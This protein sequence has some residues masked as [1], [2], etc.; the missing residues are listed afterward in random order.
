MWAVS[1]VSSGASSVTPTFPPPGPLT[2]RALQFFL[3][4]LL[5][6]GT[7]ASEREREQRVRV[8]GGSERAR[9]RSEREK[10]WASERERGG[11]SERDGG[12]REGHER[13]R[14]EREGLVYWSWTSDSWDILVGHSP[15]KL[16]TFTPMRESRPC[17]ARILPLC[18]TRPPPS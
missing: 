7:G 9:G 14:E 17:P 16:E 8:T 6:E 15:C 4:F 2:A 5:V 3:L 13:L 1:S 18:P 12:D 11:A 10:G